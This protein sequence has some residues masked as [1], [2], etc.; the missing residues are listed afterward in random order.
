MAALYSRGSMCHEYAAGK[1][2]AV[3][4]NFPGSGERHIC[5]TSLSSACF[6][7]NAQIMGVP[8]TYDWKETKFQANIMIASGYFR[9]GK[10]TR[11]FSFYSTH[12]MVSKQSL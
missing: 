3:A 12:A 7:Q 1:E 8:S 2:Q 10:A 4:T 5:T 11:F 6:T 9:S